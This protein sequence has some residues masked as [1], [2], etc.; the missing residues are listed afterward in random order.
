LNKKLET[1]SLGIA[2]VVSKQS[3]LTLGLPYYQ[4]L[5][6]TG[7]H[8]PDSQWVTIMGCLAIKHGPAWYGWQANNPFKSKLASIVIQPKC[9]RQT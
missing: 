8:R 6:K 4:A 7:T 5:H 1:Q 2:D 3:N 9:S